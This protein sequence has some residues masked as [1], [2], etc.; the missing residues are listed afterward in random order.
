METNHIRVTSIDDANDIIKIQDR[1]LGQLVR[2]NA[3]LKQKA[4][5]YDDIVTLKKLLDDRFPD[6][7]D[8]KPTNQ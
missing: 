1:L 2:E 5:M 6:G 3:V 8:Y 7:V 4:D